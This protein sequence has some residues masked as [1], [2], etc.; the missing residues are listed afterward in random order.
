MHQQ[1]GHIRGR[2]AADAR[3]LP[4]G[5]RAQRGKLLP[6]LQA[7]AVK[8]CIFDAVGKKRILQTAETLHLR[9][10]FFDVAIVA[11]HD[12]HLLAHILRKRGQRCIKPH[13]LGVA[14]AGA[15]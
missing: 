13:E 5:A 2:N 12:L 10:L 9:V 14:D 7:E 4:N 6:G 15:L 8:R 3:S 1:H 11:R